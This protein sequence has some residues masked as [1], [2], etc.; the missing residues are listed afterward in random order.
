MLIVFFSLDN[1]SIN[2]FNKSLA[3]IAKNFELAKEE[4]KQL[5]LLREEAIANAIS[6]KEKEL[7]NLETN[8]LQAQKEATENVAEKLREKE[9]KVNELIEEK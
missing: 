6:E 1:G 8:K 7:V 2:G 5:I 9:T 3:K 4:Q